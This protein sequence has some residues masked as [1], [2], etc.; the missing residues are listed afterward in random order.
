LGSGKDFAG[1]LSISTLTDRKDFSFGEIRRVGRD[2]RTQLLRKNSALA[3]MFGPEFS[4][5]GEK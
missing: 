4:V 5:V 1:G 2:L 3:E